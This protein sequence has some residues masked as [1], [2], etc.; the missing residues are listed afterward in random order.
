MNDIAIRDD[1][2]TRAEA[3][4][5]AEWF[6]TLGD[7]TRIQLLAW[8]ARRAEPAAVRDLVAVF[9][10]SQSTISHH[11]AAL[12][13]TCFVTCERVGTS[14]FYAINPDCLQALPGAADA[15]MNGR[16]PIRCL[17][18]AG[19]CDCGPDGDLDSGGPSD[20]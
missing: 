19:A 11:L 7:P 15:I 13:R 17:P 4:Q 12:A 1:V 18:A 10:H 14:S 3:E 20:E 9:P 6:A 5:V 2:L 8:L 16:A